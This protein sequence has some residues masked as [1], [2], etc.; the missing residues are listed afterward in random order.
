MRVWGL[1]GFLLTE[2]TPRSG[3][4]LPH[5]SAGFTQPT[6][7]R[8]DTCPSVPDTLA[9]A[10]L[11]VRSPCPLQADHSF[12]GLRQCTVSFRNPV[13]GRDDTGKTTL[14]KERTS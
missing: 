14:V 2:T 11:K 5:H 1:V 13:F 3:P 10:H 12:L 9:E 8:A 4:S 7:R 6:G